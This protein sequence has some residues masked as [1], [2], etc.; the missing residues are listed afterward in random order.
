[1][2]SLKFVPT[3][4][5]ALAAKPACVNGDRSELLRGRRVRWAE[6]RLKG[7]LRQT[8]KAGS[9]EPKNDYSQGTPAEGTATPPGM[10]CITI[11][12]HAIRSQTAD[13]GT[14]SMRNVRSHIPWRNNRQRWL[15]IGAQIPKVESVVPAPSC[16]GKPPGRSIVDAST[17]IENG[18]VSSIKSRKA[19]HRHLRRF[20]QQET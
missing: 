3:S 17:S 8:M 13:A 1:M 7:H 19:A 6:T 11:P 9:R 14:G 10:V 15:T 18:R 2:S 4:R 20:H 12:R 5:G 16:G